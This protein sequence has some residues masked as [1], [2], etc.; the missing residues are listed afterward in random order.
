MRL[1]MAMVADAKTFSKCGTRPGSARLQVQHAWAMWMSWGVAPPAVSESDLHI[2]S[3]MR[4]MLGFQKH[5]LQIPE[6]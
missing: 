2:G 3:D 1:C 5:A 6:T 4:A